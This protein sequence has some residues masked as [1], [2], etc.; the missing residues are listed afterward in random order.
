[1]S[2]A[3]GT[4]LQLV[5]RTPSELFVGLSNGE[6]DLI[7][8]SVPTP[9]IEVEILPLYEYELRLLVPKAAAQKY[10]G[11]LR[12]NISGAEILTLPDSYHPPIFS[13]LRSALAPANVRWTE[14]AEPSFQALIHYSTMMG[15]ATLAPDFTA[16]LPAMRDDMDV[17][18]IR[19]VPL[20]VQWGLMRRPGYHKKAPENF[21]RAAASS[22]LTRQAA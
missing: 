3:L 21:W 10:V 2:Q 5:S 14:C 4:E 18:I 6:F 1:M 15:V 13:W 22:S 8:T 19:D 12:G 11:A 16:T 17:R 7:L 9:D 20:K